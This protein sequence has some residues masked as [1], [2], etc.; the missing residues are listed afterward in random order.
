MISAAG[1][2]VAQAPWG[3]VQLAA[4]AAVRRNEIAGA[5]SSQMTA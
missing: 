5:D 1:D 3:A 2:G 4:W